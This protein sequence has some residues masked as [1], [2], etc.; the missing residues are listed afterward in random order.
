MEERHRLLL[1]KQNPQWVGEK[2]ETPEFKRDIFYKLEKYLAYKQII[3]LVGLRRVGKT[4]ILKQLMKSIVSEPSNICYISFDDRDFQKYEMAWELIGYFLQNSKGGPKY[5]FLD[6]IQKIPNWQDLLK[7]VYDTEKNLKIIVSGSSALDFKKHKETLAGRILTF[8]TPIL[9]FREFARYIGLE[10]K[11]DLKTISAEYDL[12]FLIKK[13]LYEKAFEDYLVRGAFPELLEKTDEE[14]IKKYIS[15]V[16]EKVI[17]DISKNIGKETEISDMIALLSKSTAREFE[18]N[19]L[20]SILKINRNTASSYLGLIEKA[21]LVKTA[22]NYTASTA[23]RLRVSKKGY[24]AHSSIAIAILNYPIQIISIQGIDL[25]HLVETVIA[26]NLSEFSFWKQQNNE[27]DIVFNGEPIEVKYQS[28]ITKSDM[29]SVIKFMQK[30]K[31][32]R[33][34]LITKNIFE[35]K[36]EGGREIFLIPAWLFLL[37]F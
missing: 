4:V 27:V 11:A 12:K 33:G 14:Y 32:K 30:F 22:Y 19:S 5:L 31:V 6:E 35:K 25:G 15:E 28:Q 16:I 10:S 13:H 3:G 21:F 23:K 34:F 37:L 2:I 26:S 7:T 8:N 36:Q 29:G 9:T 17:V 24:I 20:S 1:I 18:I